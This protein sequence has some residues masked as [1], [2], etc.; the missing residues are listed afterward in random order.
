MKQFQG[1]R[2]GAHDYQKSVI[3]FSRTLR[4]AMIDY[5]LLRRD[6]VISDEQL[7]TLHAYLVFTARRILDE[8]HWPHSRTWLHPD[9]PESTRDIYT[10]PG[11]HRADKLVWTNCLPNFQSDPMCALAHLSALIPEHPDAPAWRRFALD[12][13]ERQLDA[14][15]SSSGAWEES[16]NYALYTMSY[17]VATFRILKNRCGIDYFKDKRVRSVAAW[18]VH[19]FG[20]YDKRFDAYSF[21]GIGNCRVPQ[22]YC[23]CLL[24]YAGELEEND[25][26]RG[27]LIAIYQKMDALMAPTEFRPLLLAMAPT[28]ERE[29]PIR[30][31]VSEHMDQLG[32]AMRHGHP[33]PTESYLFQKI[34]FFKDHYE[35]DET[36]INCS[37][38]A[39]RWRWSMAPTRATP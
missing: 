39:R 28:P 33:S 16:I 36:A 17:F 31:L 8:G 18:L 34:G 1:F 38:R 25:P 12:D 6:R 30:P 14:Y 2:E 10:Y 29:Y 3:G 9:H 37:P 20:P 7:A 22:Q 13:L 27:D 19:F 35:A 23:E 24:T 11:E 15:A 4:D 21:P 5:E 26:L 32:V